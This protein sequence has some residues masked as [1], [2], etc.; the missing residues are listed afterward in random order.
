M[1]YTRS[2]PLKDWFGLR[3]EAIDTLAAAHTAM[4][5]VAGP[6]PPLKLGKPVAHA[7]VLRVVAE[8]QGFARDLHDLAVEKRSSC[9]GRSHGSGRF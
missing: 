2:D 3:R 4:G 8:F 7:Y 5:E 1:S 6:G 9:R